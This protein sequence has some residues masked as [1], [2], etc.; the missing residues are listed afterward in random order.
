MLLGEE[1]E[2]YFG[3]EI[4]RLEAFEDDGLLEWDSQALRVTPSGRL[5]LGNI[6][7]VFDAY[8]ERAGAGPG[9]W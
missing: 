1:R 3:P 5:F 7:M 9:V 6:T 8:V 4:D 2:D